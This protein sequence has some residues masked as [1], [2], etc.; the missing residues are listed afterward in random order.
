[1]F[2]DRMSQ[3]ILFQGAS[4]SGKS[5][6]FGKL[7]TQTVISTSTPVEEDMGSANTGG[8]FEIMKKLD[9]ALQILRYMGC[10]QTPETGASDRHATVVQVLFDSQ[11]AFVG[12]QISSQLLDKN[13]FCE[14][15]TGR[16][17]QIL[18]ALRCA[19]HKFLHLDPETNYHYLSGAGHTPPTEEDAANWENFL[20]CLNELEVTRNDTSFVLQLLAAVV[21]IGNMDFTSE[22]HTKSGKAARCVPT[23]LGLFKLV[24][25]L[26]WVDEELVL[27]CLVGPTR[28]GLP[29]VEVA[30][31]NCHILA[32]TVY[33]SLFQ[34]IVQ[35]GNRL[36]EGPNMEEAEFSVGLMDFPGLVKE[37]TYGAL[38]CNLMSEMLSQRTWRRY[39]GTDSAK[40][41]AEGLEGDVAMPAPKS[42]GVLEVMVGGQYPGVLSIVA[43]IGAMS[44]E[45]L[46][47]LLTKMTEVEPSTSVLSKVTEGSFT[48]EHT[49]GAVEYDSEIVLQ[50]C[51]LVLSE[52]IVAACSQSGNRILRAEST[53]LKTVELSNFDGFKIMAN[54]L[55]GEVNPYSTSVVQCVRASNSKGQCDQKSM[56]YQL[57]DSVLSPL[58][59]WQKNGFTDYIPHGQFVRD[60]R[61]FLSDEELVQCPL[62]ECCFRILS[63]ILS[64]DAYAIGERNVL[65][66]GSKT[67]ALTSVLVA[68][69]EAAAIL[70]QKRT[71]GALARI[72][73]H[74]MKRI[75]MAATLNIQRVWRGYI[76]RVEYAVMHEN[77]HWAHSLVARN[78]RGHVARLAVIRRFPS[79]LYNEAYTVFEGLS[80]YEKAYHAAV[81]FKKIMVGHITRKWYQEFR[82]LKLTAAID[83]QRIFRGYIGR[84]RALGL[85]S[86]VYAC[87]VIQEA[88]IKRL[89]RLNAAS[90]KIQ[91]AWRAI[92][93]ER[94]FGWVHEKLTL[95]AIDIQR[96]YRGHR[97]RVLAYK[98]RVASQCWK[99][100]KAAT[101]IQRWWRPIMNK[102][103]AARL[104]GAA[105]R[106]QRAWRSAV[107][108]AAW[109]WVH[110][111]LNE[112]ATAITRS[113][114]GFKTRQRVL[115]LKA[116]TAHQSML[117]RPPGGGGD[118]TEDGFSTARDSEQDYDGAGP[119]STARGSTVSH[120]QVSS[121][122]GAM[123]SVQG[124][125]EQ[126]LSMME[127]KGAGGGAGGRT[128][129]AKFSLGMPTAVSAENK[130]SER[131]KGGPEP[132]TPQINPRSQ[133]LAAAKR[134]KGKVEDR[135]ERLEKEKK[136]KIEAQR[137]EKLESE[138]AAMSPPKMNKK[139]R[140]MTQS[141]G[142]VPVGER[143][144]GYQQQSRANVE[145]ARIEGEKAE[146]D[147]LTFHP[148]ITKQAQ[149]MERGPAVWE[150]WY[151]DKYQR[152]KELERAV[153]CQ[154]LQ[155][156]RDPQ[157]SKG[158]AKLAAKRP[159]ADSKVYD[160]LYAYQNRYKANRENLM[161]EEEERFAQTASTRQPSS[162]DKNRK[163]AEKR[164]Q[165]AYED[166]YDETPSQ[167]FSTVSAAG[168]ARHKFTPQVN[169]H[170]TNIVREKQERA[171]QMM[172]GPDSARS[173]GSS[174]TP[175]VYGVT[176]RKGDKGHDKS[177]TKWNTML[178]GFKRDFEY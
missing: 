109:E 172:E 5:F 152:L 168:T 124:G 96:I 58:L 175:R 123:S 97:G 88:Y 37:G 23:D 133:Q 169:D 167:L 70:V 156:V 56:C 121:K 16:S 55:L 150:Q 46:C 127:S 79:R 62:K 12:A 76:A 42:Q 31:Q 129:K 125:G 1:M 155:D 139:S 73:Y 4:G 83:I 151:K 57:Q 110:F 25:S 141:L 14:L 45:T 177:K 75:V 95:A 15:P 22:G 157:I 81:V 54:D 140:K 13:R 174:S 8:G 90:T 77:V 28:Q 144:L 142:R 164:R 84:Q 72:R 41:R 49:G 67:K 108:R 159:D 106:I 165:G 39:L 51:S 94:A 48:V 2:K 32:Q 64:P 170:S 66:K 38:C 154:D 34:F 92:M 137:R 143:L 145:R 26:L 149:A 17:F 43:E 112:A 30:R 158:T 119:M 161:R 135:F 162:Y 52:T 65:L 98:C 166:S 18:H 147:N 163:A 176:D 128:R 111:Q 71:R 53:E 105:I 173:Y 50:A 131:R 63:G 134:G 40:L 89:V 117:D 3:A 74:R 93:A 80:Q 120:G 115:A 102:V 20:Q 78:Y 103:L 82:F 6:S 44:T 178:N 130:A 24:C 87:C 148:Q 104:E 10:V 35:Q 146:Q 60:Y 136:E 118:E 21:H 59:A 101:Q 68:R 61:I 171:L 69:R 27:E 99:W 33:D 122:G 153:R 132:F 7:L 29:T 113:W 116:S 19:P 138:L 9:A 100:W 107:A 126:D 86:R 47:S 85:A 91:R 11:P 160:R 114:R 36:L